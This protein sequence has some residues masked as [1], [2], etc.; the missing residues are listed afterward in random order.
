[1][2]DCSLGLSPSAKRFLL[3]RT[4]NKRWREFLLKLP[5]AANSRALNAL[6]SAA[7][8]IHSMAD[9]ALFAPFFQIGMFFSR[10]RASFTGPFS[11][12]PWFRSAAL[13]A[14]QNRAF[15][16]ARARQFGVPLL[17]G[18]S[19]SLPLHSGSWLEGLLLPWRVSH[20][21]RRFPGL[22]LRNP[23]LPC[24]ASHHARI[25]FMPIFG[26]LPA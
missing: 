17:R 12:F 9:Q 15:H 2:I 4:K 1:M 26:A 19:C 13:R 7:A 21:C 5:A 25:G 14:F 18:I 16:F 20:A 3:A 11:Q 22:L 24:K 8:I 6:A 10:Q 23:Y